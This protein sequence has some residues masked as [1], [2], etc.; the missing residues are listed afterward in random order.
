MTEKALGAG[1]GKPED[2]TTAYSA[3]EEEDFLKTPDS[4]LITDFRR[5]YDIPDSAVVLATIA[6]LFELKGHSF[7]IG[8]A[9]ELAA[10]FDK[11]IWL[12]VGDGSLAGK[13]KTEI[14]LASLD[15]KFKF[16]G[17]MAPEQIPLAIHSSDILVHCSLREGLARVLPQAML[18]G[19][20]TVSFDVD[21]AREVVNKNTGRLVE[22]KDVR[23]LTDACA[24]LI[25]DSQLRK[26][27]GNNARY[28]V[29]EMFAPRTMVDTI[30][31][32][33]KRLTDK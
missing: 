22:P 18:C 15:H 10:R 20:P 1:I 11:C 6:R 25:Q 5:K 8:S 3:I 19:K 27:L 21:G 9:K 23:Q 30:E 17:L 33:Y 7:I 12:F 13:I 28:S 29:K 31:Q 16:T 14:R 32:V 26:D 4:Q 24:E 2:F